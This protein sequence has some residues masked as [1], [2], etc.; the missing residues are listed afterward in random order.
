MVNWIGALGR[1]LLSSANNPG[2]NSHF[3]DVP[4]IESIDLLGNA[5][6]FSSPGSDALFLLRLLFRLECFF[7]HPGHDSRLSAFR[8]QF[9]ASYLTTAT[10]R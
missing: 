8:K 9:S 7:S 10:T 5:F 2:S 1:R 4:P 3:L 6:C